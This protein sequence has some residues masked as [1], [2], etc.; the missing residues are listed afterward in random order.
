MHFSLPIGPGVCSTP[1]ETAV[2]SGMVIFISECRNKGV[3]HIHPNEFSIH[4]YRNSGIGTHFYKASSL[5]QNTVLFQQLMPI[6]A[7]YVI[8][9]GTHYLLMGGQRQH[10]MRSLPDNS[11]HPHWW[12]SNLRPDFESSDLSTQPCAATD[13][14]LYRLLTSPL[15]LYTLQ[16]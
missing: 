10:G 2:L 5:G 11:V 14:W 4:R 13:L 9:P 8:P 6:T 3:P 12:K 1:I 7:Q 15:L 16:S